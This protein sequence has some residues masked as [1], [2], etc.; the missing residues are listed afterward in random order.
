MRDFDP[1]PYFGPKEVRR[2]DRVTQLGFA[3]AAD[4]LDDA[5]ELGADPGRCAVIAATGIG[6]LSTLEENNKAY[7]ERGAV[8]GQP[9][10]RADD[11]AERHAPA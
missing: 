6:G 11:D 8:T 4:A 2:Q 9:V 3:A 7:F 10:L 5:G 1:E